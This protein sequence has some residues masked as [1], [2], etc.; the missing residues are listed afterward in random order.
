[1]LEKPNAAEDGTDRH[2]EFA[3]RS[4]GLVTPPSE[5]F[6]KNRGWDEAS[7]KGS[8]RVGCIRPWWE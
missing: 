2:V 8:K 1:M 6:G 7:S 4:G 3:L 5:T